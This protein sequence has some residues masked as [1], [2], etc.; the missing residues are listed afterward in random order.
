MAFGSTFNKRDPR[1]QQAMLR[2]GSRGFT[3]TPGG[4]RGL[5]R[6]ITGNF[7]GEQLR[8]DL[9]FADIFD[10][11][12]YFQENMGLKKRQLAFDDKMFDKKMKSEERGIMITT[13]AGLG[14][15]VLN[16][17]Q[18]KRRAAMQR[19]ESLREKALQAEIGMLRAEHRHGMSRDEWQ[20]DDPTPYL[21]YR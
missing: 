17:M 5:Q 15:G 12:R 19:E 21:P 3:A 2:A 6:K 7:A 11:H 13:A 16:Y 9:E 20:T 14:T 18:G 1:Y 10:K 8:K 4:V